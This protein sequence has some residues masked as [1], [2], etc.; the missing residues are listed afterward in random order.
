MPI[1]GVQLQTLEL[2]NSPIESIPE[3]L[4]DCTSL[5]Y[6]YLIDCRISIARYNR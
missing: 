4:C 3:S 5:Q 2:R 6:L 1:L